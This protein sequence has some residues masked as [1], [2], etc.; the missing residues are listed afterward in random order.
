MEKQSRKR[1]A[2]IGA[3]SVGAVLALALGGTAAQAHD[4]AKGSGGGPLRSLVTDGTITQ[5]EATAIRDALQSQ[6]ETDREAKQAEKAAQ[7]KSALAPLVAKGTITQTQ[8]DAIAAHTR[9]TLSTEQRSAVREALN[10]VRESNRTAHQAEEKAERDAA[11]A[12]L[13]SSGT[14]NQAQADAV[15][16]ALASSHAD[17]MDGRGPKE[18]HGKFGGNKGGGRN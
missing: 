6:R 7:V 4:G 15:T 3:V 11:I 9:V 8:A 14:L 16:A 12:A 2:V 5:D 1:A 10:S 13:V 17:R 18:G